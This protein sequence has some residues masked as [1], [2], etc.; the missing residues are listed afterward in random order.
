MTALPA[1]VLYVSYDGLLEPLGES[2]V[3]AY[4]EALAL[5]GTSLAVLSFEKP[6]DLGDDARVEAMRTRLS[7]AAVDWIP[8]RYHRSPSLPATAY[9]VAGGVRAARSYLRGRRVALVHG[10]G[11]TGGLIAVMIARRSDA[12]F[13]FDMRGFW[14]DERIE[15]GQWAEASLLVRGLRALE[16]RLLAEADAIV[17]LTEAGA[18]ALPSL[19]PGVALPRVEVIPPAS[20]SSASSLQKTRVRCGAGSDWARGSFSSIQDHSACVTWVPS[21]C[22]SGSGSK[23]RAVGSWSSPGRW[24]SPPAWPRRKGCT[25]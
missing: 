5:R 24:S 22:E 6:G 16:K 7:R 3:V 4:V 23:R 9:D 1:T 21:R 19:A 10:R 14:V 17:S 25:P 15:A 8:L 12:R 18:E 2:Q 11:Y 13:L 20:T